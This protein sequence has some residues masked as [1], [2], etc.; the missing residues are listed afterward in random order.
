MIWI[1]EYKV[2]NKIYKDTLDL[3]TLDEKSVEKWFKKNKNDII[4]S[5][6]SGDFHSVKVKPKFIKCYLKNFTI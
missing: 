5:Y 6:M 2:S 1:V 3:N 4:L